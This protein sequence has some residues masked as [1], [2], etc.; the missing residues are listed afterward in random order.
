[1]KMDSFSRPAICLCLIL[2]AGCSEGPTETTAAERARR[3][4]AEDKSTLPITPEELRRRLGTNEMATFLMSGNDIVEANLYQSGI[5]SVEGLKGLPLRAI[6]LGFT[7][8]KD[9]TPLKGMKL[10]SLV[11]ENTPVSDL[12]PIKEMPLELLKLQNTAV[13]DFSPLKGLKLKELNVLNLPFFDLSLL[14][15]MPLEQLWLDG[16]QVEGLE[17]L[18]ISGLVSL[19]VERTA[20]ADLTPVSTM[21]TL[22]RLNIAQTQVSDLTPLKGLRLERIILTPER[23]RTGM[24]SL[25]EMKSLVLIQTSVEQQLSADDFWKRYDLGLF[26]PAETPAEN[27]ASPDA[28]NGNNGA[29]PPK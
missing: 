2:L 7:R 17:Q 8:V 9:L 20:V 18:P 5:R 11:L 25:R 15:D 26:K 29:E 12:S 21:T 6:D 16:T 24:E 19:N 27:P 23:I 14:Q 4:A 13:T 22:R 28:A 10:K 1:M 3:I